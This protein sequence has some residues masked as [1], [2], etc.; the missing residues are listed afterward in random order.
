MIAL[1]TLAPPSTNA[2]VMEL[3]ST[4]FVFA[5]TGSKGAIAQKILV[6][7]TATPNVVLENA[8]T[9][10][11]SALL[12][13]AGRTAAKT[14]VDSI[15]LDTAAAAKVCALALTVI[16]ASTASKTCVP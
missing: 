5:N 1:T 9:G 3:A 10:N 8:S 6:P 15:V 14:F 4:E 2:L 13:W 11:A 7:T 12:V 16:W